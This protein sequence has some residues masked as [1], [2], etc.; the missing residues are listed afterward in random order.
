MVTMSYNI[1]IVD[2]PINIFVPSFIHLTYPKHPGFP[3]PIHHYFSPPNLLVNT[4][5]NAVYLLRFF[6]SSSRNEG[7][8]GS[9]GGSRS[10]SALASVEDGGHVR[11]TR[12]EYCTPDS[13]THVVT[14]K[15][16]YDTG[17]TSKVS[18][19]AS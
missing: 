1:F 13:K 6:R 16:E 15:Y 12:R 3:S 14:E 19:E 5:D 4:P 2:E 10:G 18:Y 17:D 11:H 9:R 7:R 8:S